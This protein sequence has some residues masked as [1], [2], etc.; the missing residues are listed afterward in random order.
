MNNRWLLS[1]IVFLSVHSFAHG[2]DGSESMD[3]E[4]P[5]EKPA[6]YTQQP[7]SLLLMLPN[8]VQQ[9]VLFYVGEPTFME[10]DWMTK[11]F[12]YNPEKL[13]YVIRDK[14]VRRGV[15]IERAFYPCAYSCKQLST[16]VTTLSKERKE[17]IKEEYTLEKI[18]QALQEALSRHETSLH[19]IISS[20]PAIID[21]SVLGYAVSFSS[22]TVPNII[23]VILRASDDPQKL[24][25]FKNSVNRTV[26]HYAAISCDKKEVFIMLF[27]AAGDHARELLTI[28]DTY[29]STNSVDGLA[30]VNNNKA[31]F[32]AV[33]E[34]FGDDQLDNTE[35]AEEDSL[36]FCSI[37]CS[38]HA[39]CT[40]I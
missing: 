17:L 5:E 38:S 40:I 25:L 24:V 27:E 13:V 33:E 15:S 18:A 35:S 21:N 19:E 37:L 9:H 4:L 28:R 16:N 1:L 26:L 6:L 30:Q 22:K 11:K 2:M 10:S 32:A 14:F 12:K 29:K 7:N 36:N 20:K 3:V 8:E 31:F 34:F 23:E 39:F